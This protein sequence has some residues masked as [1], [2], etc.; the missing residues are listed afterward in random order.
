METKGDNREAPFG[1]C[2]HLEKKVLERSTQLGV[3]L[4]P[5]E[6]SSVLKDLLRWSRVNTDE[7]HPVKTRDGSYTYI[8]PGYG[9]PFHSVSA[10]AITES[11]GKFIKPSLLI[12]LARSRPSVCIVDIGFGLGYNSS[13]AVFIA[14]RLNPRA[15]I[16]LHAFDKREPEKVLKLP[17]PFG[18]VQ[19]KLLSLLPSGEREGIKIEFYKGDVRERLP[20]APIHDADVV[21]HDP[22]SPYRNPEVWTLELFK[23]LKSKM[24]RS[25]VWVSYSSSLPVRKSLLLLGFNVGETKPLGRKR[26]GTCASPGLT[27]RLPSRWML[28]LKS[29]PYSIPFRDPK[30]NREPVDILID[31]RLSVLLRER[32]FSSG[33][34]K[35]IPRSPSLLW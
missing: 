15:E 11:L 6:L 7:Y 33:R 22:F 27:F 23:K 34:S 1:A 8:D 21:F 24:S 29:S 5:K 20:S 16:I 10:G 25:G 13:L 30:L 3:E 32:E 26:G 4:S 9:E 35:E 14:K 2:N 28:K 18:Q 31:Y 17:E 19:K 12:S